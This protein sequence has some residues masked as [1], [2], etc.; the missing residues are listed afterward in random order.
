LF[1]STPHLLH[2]FSLLALSACNNSGTVGEASAK[3]QTEDTEAFVPAESDLVKPEDR[4]ARFF[5]AEG[6]E[7]REVA[8][9]QKGW[10][11]V[12]RGYFSLYIL[13]EEEVTDDVLAKIHPTFNAWSLL[14][15]LKITKATDLYRLLNANRGGL[16]LP[17]FELGLLEQCPP[18]SGV[19]RWEHIYVRG[20]HTV[21]QRLFDCNPKI[22]FDLERTERIEVPL[23][24]LTMRWIKVVHVGEKLD[25]NSVENLRSF[26]GVV[27]IHAAKYPDWLDDGITGAQWASLSIQ[28]LTELTAKQ[29][30]SIGQLRDKTISMPD[31]QSLSPAAAGELDGKGKLFLPSLEKISPKAMGHL[32]AQRAQLTLGITEISPA[33]MAAIQGSKDTRME[34]LNVTDLSLRTIRIGMAPVTRELRLGRLKEFDA[35]RLEALI[36]RD[37]SPS[38]RK[39]GMVFF[40]IERLEM[41]LFLAADQAVDKKRI[42]RPNTHLRGRFIQ[43]A[44]EIDPEVIRHL[45]NEDK[46][47]GHER[48]W[49]NLGH[50]PP[51]TAKIL[52]EYQ[53]NIQL[54][55]LEELSN[56][57]L[58]ILA[59]AKT[60]LA[61]DGLT[62]LKP[63]QAEILGASQVGELSLKG[64]ETISPAQLE[65]FREFQGKLV[66][67]NWILYSYE[68]MPYLLNHGASLDTW[69][70]HPE[71]F[72]QIQNLKASSL[73]LEGLRE[74]TAEQAVHISRF[75]GDKLWV[76][77]PELTPGIAKALSQ[78][79]GSQL[80]LKLNTEPTRKE[81]TK[82]ALWE[83][84][85]FQGSLGIS[86]NTKLNESLL[87]PLIRDFTGQSL[88][89]RPT[90]EI[91]TEELMQAFVGSSYDELGIQA[92]SYSK[93]GMDILAAHPQKKLHGRIPVAALCD[94]GGVSVPQNFEN[95]YCIELLEM[96]GEDTGP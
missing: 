58:S 88:G 95:D 30:R 50:I 9:N 55:G 41:E 60:R 57:S 82:E 24:K 37:L 26:P 94:G 31:L 72:V 53:E 65:H 8:T 39:A 18:E 70:I 11:G 19:K 47:K 79:Q 28:G 51:E 84:R 92:E 85:H 96:E 71:A 32:T 29:A 4:F 14:P 78:F 59:K 76:K 91:L 64:L 54:A 21:T 69:R 90:L 5:E 83:L 10:N 87:L 67:E 12:S 42:R 2:L 89:V 15:N 23:T 34:L 46:S 49:P 48:I 13:K 3:Q 7:F 25:A 27:T 62:R 61:L 56:E 45:L 40:T 66:L 80:H 33:T 1:N 81:P 38:G 43:K 63:G 22:Q 86:A 75:P 17:S 44:R 74:L 77:V 6:L 16:Y 20:S 68:A 35:E 73:K 93:A 36:E 52:V